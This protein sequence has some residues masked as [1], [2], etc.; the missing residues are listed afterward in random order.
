MPGTM[1]QAD[2]VAD[3]KASLND[4]AS[5]FVA[6]A[7]ADFIRHLDMAALDFSRFK[8][9]TMLGSVALTADKYDYAA[10]ADFLSFKATIW[11]TDRPRTQPWERS[12]T[13]M[14]PNV[15]AAENAGAHELHL[16]PAPSEAQI[17]VF[18]ATYKFYYFARH[19][20]GSTAATTSVLLGDRG[21]LLVRAQAEAM[22]EL[23]VR[24]SKKVVQMRDGISGGTKNGTPAYLYESLM[25]QFERMAA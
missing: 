2:L 21:L 15:R 18:G 20:I 22:K 1:S 8:P 3:L 19:V 24:N 16:L 12:Y 9:R 7:D 23:A 14:L 25:A 6:A 17:S 13:G 5:V 11:S 4:A 10:P